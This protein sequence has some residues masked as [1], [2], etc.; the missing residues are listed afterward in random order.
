MMQGGQM[1]S[2]LRP[3]NH[4][5]AVCK[6]G[7]MLSTAFFNITCLAKQSTASGRVRHYDGCTGSME[8]HIE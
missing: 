6:G 1:M 2:R 8:L 3:A 5:T 7:S 4:N